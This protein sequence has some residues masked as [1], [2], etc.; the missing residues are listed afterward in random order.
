MSTL[1]IKRVLYFEAKKLAVN[2]PRGSE[3]LTLCDTPG[4]MA[5][6]PIAIGLNA[7]RG[8]YE[9]YAEDIDPSNVFGRI[10]TLKDDTGSDLAFSELEN[11]S[12]FGFEIRVTGKVNPTTVTGTITEFIASG[13]A[14]V[15]TD[16]LEDE[17]KKE[18]ER[19]VLEGLC[20]EE[21]VDEVIQVMKRNRVEDYLIVRT[22]KS[23]SKYEVPAHYPKTMYVDVTPTTADESLFSECLRNALDGFPIV[24]EGGKSVGKNVC[25]E[26]IA[27][28][29]QRPFFLT[30][31]SKG[32]GRDEIFGSKTTEN[33]ASEGLSL[34]DAFEYVALM[35]N[36]A[37]SKES[38]ERAAK[39]EYYKAKAASV[40]IVQEVSEFVKWLKVGGVMVFNEM[41][42]A[43]ANFFSSFANQLTDN[44]GF[45]N[46]PGIGRVAIHEKCILIGG[47]NPGYQG[48]QAQ[49]DATMSRFGSITF[50]APKS[51]KGI[52]EENLKGRLDKEY[53]KQAEECY[54]VLLDNAENNIVPDAV[55]NIRGF[56]RALES[57]ANSGCRARLFRQLEIHVVGT[58]PIRSRET[59]SMVISQKVS[60]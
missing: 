54:K 10:M 22:L 8:Y 12:P 41:N 18:K 24:Y 28:C 43:E 21:I 37:L 31:F 13:V 4:A 6:L 50:P 48:T 17:I 27:F 30:S 57:V 58:C 55:L 44:T 3:I 35:Q 23:Y 9:A 25:A 42:M 29:L 39:F 16:S 51:I 53:I 45:V 34:E 20:P 40:S 33:S 15:Q 26:T 32:M 2:C 59:V 5:A 19:V 46:C 1:N 52:L 47:Q 38:M 60:L 11:L 7:G 36:K 14:S 56:V 49:N